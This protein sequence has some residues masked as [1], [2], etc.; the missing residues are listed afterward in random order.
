MVV[1]EAAWVLQSWKMHLQKIGPPSKNGKDVVSF[2]EGL[3]LSKGKR[4]A[5]V[6]YH[7]LK[8]I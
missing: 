8:I 6:G 3:V 1:L 7:M 4:A 5:N 2:S